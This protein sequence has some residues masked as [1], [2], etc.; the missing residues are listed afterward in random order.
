MQLVDASLT[1]QN[2]NAIATAIRAKLRQR[3]SNEKLQGQLLNNND[4]F[5]ETIR[6][7]LTGYL[8]STQFWNFSRCG[9]EEIY[10]TCEQCGQ[11]E[12]MDYRCNL[13]WCPR[14]QQRLGAIRRNLISHWA[15]KITQ[16]K[17]LVLTQRNFPVLTR[18]EIRQ[19]TQR[20]A[21]MRRSKCFAKVRGGCV[22]TEITNEERGWHLHAHLLLDVKWLDM[23]KVAV[24][25]GKLVGQE[26]AIVKIKDVREK[27]YL[28]EI[29]K[30]VVE[31]SE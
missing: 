27:D 16:P 21:K 18:K 28:Q 15:K 1:M 22:S 7:K 14:C 19:L 5:A 8:D 23:E 26:F 10:R 30:Y 3:V 20:L 17:H 31:G 24:T 9:H 13:K 25:W 6:I 29:C 12:R 4:D 2:E 11:F